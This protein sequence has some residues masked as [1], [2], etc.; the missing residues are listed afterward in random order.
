MANL[1]L[2]KVDFKNVLGRNK[3][4]NAYYENSL[5]IQFCL[6][7]GLVSVLCT[8]KDFVYFCYNGFGA[9]HLYDLM[10]WWSRVNMI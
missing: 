4:L 8:Y 9:L 7:I 3:K 6:V 2:I 1:Q 5:N 10:L